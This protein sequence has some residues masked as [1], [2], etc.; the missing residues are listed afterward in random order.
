MHIIATL[1]PANPN[2]SEMISFSAVGFLVVMAV[3]IALSTATNII[4]KFFTLFDKSAKPKA[5]APAKAAAKASVPQ[6][7]AI[8]ISAAVASVLPELKEDSAELIAVLSAAA[9]V[10]IEEECRVVSIKTVAPDMAFANQGKFQMFSNK[11]YVPV[12]AK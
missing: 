1:I 12:R 4:G 7:H 8:A 3:L 2:M 9:A 10:V 6:D 11:N 5:V